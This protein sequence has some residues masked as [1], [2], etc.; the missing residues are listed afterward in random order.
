MLGFPLADPIVGIL[1]SVAIVVLLAGTIRSI[2]RRLMDAV[3]PDLLARAEHAIEH[4][5]GI[6]KV[7]SLRLRWT[8]HRLTGDAEV[9]VDDT[10]L[11]AASALADEAVRQAHA[12]LPHLDDFTVR[13]K[14]PGIAHTASD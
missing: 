7:T 3:E 14:P 10:T 13:V 11:S 6:R 4:V 12:H 1:I 2:G 5:P 9:T 8:G